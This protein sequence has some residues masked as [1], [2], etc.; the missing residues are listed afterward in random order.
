MYHSGIKVQAKVPTSNVL[1][2]EGDEAVVQKA[3]RDIVVP[4]VQASYKGKGLEVWREFLIAERGWKDDSTV[5]NIF[6]EGNSVKDEDRQRL[7]IVFAMWLKGRG[8]V[9]RKHFQ[10]LMH[11]FR[12]NLKPTD[13]FESKTV[14]EAR[15]TMYSWDARA[16]SKA[17]DAAEKLPVTWDMLENIRENSWP[18]TKLDG[19]KAADVDKA[20]AYLAGLMMWNWGLRVSEA[21]KTQS[22]RVQLDAGKEWERA[23]DNHAMKAEDIRIGCKDNDGVMSWYGGNEWAGRKAGLLASCVGL[24]VRSSKT[25]RGGRSVKYL[26]EAGS[27]GEKLLVDLISKWADYAHFGSGEDM[28]LSRRALDPWGNPRKGQRKRLNSELVSR[29]IKECA[30]RLGLPETSYSTKS[31][32]IGGISSLRRMDVSEEDTMK[33]MDHKTTHASRHYQSAQL[34]H[35]KVPLTTV[36][37]VRSEVEP[38]PKLKEKQGPLG[39]VGRYG[40]GYGRDQ[41]DILVSGF[42]V[43]STNQSRKT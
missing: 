29:S 13:A 31:F 8:L 14:M 43:G 18:S 1:L 42:G 24:S 22:D 38:A 37:A 9:P 11:D 20:M 30:T 10:A 27:Q 28:F 34:Q 21:A 39:G 40:G 33:K 5:M 19:L 7:L 3:L 12:A 15:K 41:V 4:S 32:K 36:G 25:N 17:K 26:V 2:K 6:M 16:V 35:E 23:I